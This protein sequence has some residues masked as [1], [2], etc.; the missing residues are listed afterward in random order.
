VYN[1]IFFS[2]AID[3][4]GASGEG[5]EAGPADQ[6]TFASSNAD[7][8]GVQ[9]VALTDPEGLYTLA[10]ALV[11]YRGTRVVAQSIIPGILQGEQL[12]SLVYGSVDGGNKM[13]WNETFH[14]R[15]K[16][17][18]DALHVKESVVVDGAGAEHRLCAPVECKGILGSDNRMYL[19]DVVRVAPADPSY[20]GDQRAGGGFLRW[21]LVD[22]F[23]RARA[24]AAADAAP[25]GAPPPP[26]LALNPNVLPH[27]GAD[28]ARARPWRLAGTDTEADEALVRACAASVH[29]AAIPALVA[30]FR[31]LAASPVDGAQLVRAMHAEGVN[32]RHLGALHAAAA[33]VPYVQLLAE[34][35]MLARGCKHLLRA[36]LAATGQAHLA[37]AIAHFLNCLLGR[38]SPP[39]GGGRGA[40]KTKRKGSG[41]RGAGAADGAGPLVALGSDTLWA[42]LAAEVQAR[43]GFA[44][45]ERTA[46][47]KRADRLPLLRAVAQRAGLQLLARAYDLGA[48]Q[49][50]GPEDV[51]GLR[52]VVKGTLHAAPDAQALVAAGKALLQAG[53]P[54]SAQDALHEALQQLHQTC[55][56]LH[57]QTAECYAALAMANYH[58]RDA[59]NALACQ[60]KA[61]VIL[62]RLLGW[63]HPDVALGYGNLALFSHAL[64]EHRRAVLYIRRAEQLLLVVCGP[65][66]PDVAALYINA[67]M[68]YLDL[69]RLKPA[70]RYLHAS[71]TISE[72]VLGEGHLQSAQCLH[73]TAVALSMMAAPSLAVKNEQ[74]PLPCCSAPRYNA[75]PRVPLRA[76]TD[77]RW[78]GRAQRCLDILRAHLP[79]EDPRVTESSDWARTFAARAKMHAQQAQPAAP[80]GAAPAGAAAEP[81]GAETLKPIVFG[82]GGR[83]APAQR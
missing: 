6:A 43:F 13:V 54:A 77:P 19:L 4:G 52:P 14:E 53:S 57:E 60:Q 36:G 20:T 11:D 32:C 47:L 8:V 35:E 16:T 9:R 51:Q 34:R 7:L 81:G 24:A 50:L 63:D 70:L 67:A 33:H 12:S 79:A 41:L 64:Q 78:G 21:E 59:L 18:A 62:E 56:P 69:G 2:F 5:D 40:G 25:P 15:L 72:S 48:G 28:G 29:E 71:L 74:V 30:R 17:A 66:H 83:T 55:G 37:A 73:A 23:V 26:P 76:G 42:A 45:G 22:H 44:L 27:A 82:P 58:A 49:P 31:A 68:V 61:V 10:T 3:R 38:V 39:G 46:A 65:R 80:L 1:S 75:T